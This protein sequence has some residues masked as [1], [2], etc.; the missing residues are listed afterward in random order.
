MKDD[1]N[2]RR[3]DENRTKDERNEKHRTPQQQIPDLKWNKRPSF[4]D[5]NSFTLTVQ[6]LKIIIM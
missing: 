2:E 5:D 3:W 1:V 6:M 4:D